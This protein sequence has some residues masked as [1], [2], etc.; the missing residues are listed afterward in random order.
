MIKL[1][2]DWKNVLIII[3]LVISCIF[4]IKSCSL[5]KELNDS[6]IILSDSISYYENKS[7][8]LFLE[9]ETYILEIDDLKKINDELY[10]EVKKLKDN[11]IVVTQVKTETIIDSIE[12]ESIKY[13]YVDNE[14]I[15]YY[16]YKDDYL[17]MNIAHSLKNGN[18]K[19][20][21]D[22]IS[23]MSDIYTSIIER[24]DNLYVISRSTN[25]YLNISNING[26]LIDID[27]S[28]VL[29]N[30]YKKH[31]TFFDK[32]SIGI[33]SGITLLYDFNTQNVKGGLGMT[34]GL[35][36]KLN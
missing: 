33:T 27:N 22:N 10:S 21:V 14:H 17:S 36:Y 5:N 19:L 11:P 4:N 7:K 8:E 3:L 26:G 18:G 12:V 28:K 2:S 29:S 1:F 20:T 6:Y 24:D 34:L 13:I 9:K 25:P 15:N 30:Y 23:M 32:F 35:S 16:N 31:E